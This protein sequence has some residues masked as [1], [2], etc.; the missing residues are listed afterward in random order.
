MSG[1]SFFSGRRLLLSEVPNSLRGLLTDHRIKEYPAM[2]INGRSVQCTRCGTVHH[3]ADVRIANK[4]ETFYFCPSCIQLGR[5]QSNLS[6]YGSRR[7][8]KKDQR[9]VSLAWEGQLTPSQRKVSEKVMAAI[10]KKGSLL[11][12]AVT[13]A[14][15]TEMLFEGIQFGLAQGW[16]IALASP[17]VDVC[18]ELFPRLQRAFPTLEIALLYGKQEQD[19]Y[20]SSLVICTTHQLLRFYQ[21]FDVLIVDEVDAFPYVDNQ[22]LQRATLNARKQKS[23]HI[24]LTAT[25]TP[26]LEQEVVSGG[27]E[28]IVL[29]ARFHRHPLPVPEGRWLANWASMPQKMRVFSSFK[30]LLI[31]QLEQQRQTLIFC[32]T[33]EFLSKMTRLLV[34]E[35][36]QSAI[37][38]AYGKDRQ[39]YESI[40]AMRR[41][42]YELFLTTTILER[43]VTFADIDVIVLGSNHRVFNQSTLIQIAGR[44]GRSDDN[45]TGNVYFL[46]DGW[47]KA[48]KGAVREIRKLNRLAKEEGLIE[49]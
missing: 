13:G 10:E 20:Y 11:I 32:P 47:S 40:K 46:H 7:R 6:L 45:P 44:A 12:H 16:R 24:L 42:D 19:Y 33:V 27:L 23:A 26:A 22:L 34:K 49:T 15:K 38:S 17:R 5:V 39:R 28:K 41:R 48:M 1:L 31:G 36:P 25:S 2:C 8:P 37:G 18:L 3:S 35:F 29:P 9:S 14:G 4:F 21:A 30:Q 43:G